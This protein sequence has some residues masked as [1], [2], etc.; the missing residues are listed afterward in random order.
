MTH[1]AMTLKSA[2]P[3]KVKA[4][5]TKAGQSYDDPDFLESAKKFRQLV[6]MG[7]FYKGATGLSNDEASAL[8]YSGKVAM[9]TTGSWMAGSI[10][11]DAENP[12]DF[13]VVPF[14]LLGSNA[15]ATDFMGGAVDSIMVSAST[16]YP[17]IAGKAAF[18][19]TRSISK[20]AYLDGAG[21]AVWK[22]DYDDSS[23][24]PMTKKLADFAANATSF[25]LWFDTTMEAEDAGEYLTLLQELY[26][27]EITPEEFVSSM[28]KNL[29]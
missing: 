18:E 11:T 25:T 8:F 24:N 27:G 22:K 13:D 10:Q 12:S 23:V 19:L 20:Y 2:G 7:A 28:K 21:L 9:Y 14:P 16:K 29:E 15:K 6:E 5:L 17:D 26:V 3:E 1:D 4:A